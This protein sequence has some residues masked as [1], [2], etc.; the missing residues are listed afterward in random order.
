MSELDGIIPALVYENYKSPLK[1]VPKDKGFGYYG[2]IALTKDRSLMQCHICG[3]LYASVA[4]HIRKHK[5]DADEYRERFQLA[6]GSSLIGESTREKYQQHA[7]ARIASI[8]AGVPAH[9]IKRNADIRAGLIIPPPGYETAF[10]R[11]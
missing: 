1:E 3:E 8:S 10:S 4:L 2:V 9:I 7:L 11:I 5:M 6:R